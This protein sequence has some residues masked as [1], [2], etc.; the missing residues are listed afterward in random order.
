MANK[1]AARQTES[2][3]KQDKPNKTESEVR[4]QGGE[5]ETEGESRSQVEEE[6]GG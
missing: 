4:D 2:R 6:E 1:A 5:R 3:I